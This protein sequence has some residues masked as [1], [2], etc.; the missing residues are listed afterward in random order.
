[1]LTSSAMPERKKSALG[2]WLGDLKIETR[3]GVFAK[4]DIDFCTRLLVERVRPRDPEETLCDLGAG[5]GVVGISF[6]KQVERVVFLEANL[7]AVKTCRENLRRNK[8]ANGEVFLSDVFAEFDEEKPGEK[9]SLILSNPP[10]H[11]GKDLVKEFL[12][13]ARRHLLPGGRF[14]LACRKDLPFDRWAAEIFEE[15]GGGAKISFR[16]P[17]AK[18]VEAWMPRQEKS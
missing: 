17:R 10:I 15:R 12:L 5:S 16:S 9:F 8:I 4:Q 2:F 18:L 14:F 13:G 1:L 7:R 3:P 11:G 6:A